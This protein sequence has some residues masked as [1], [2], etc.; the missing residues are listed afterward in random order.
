MKTLKAQRGFFDFGLGLTLLAI[1]G[2]SAVTIDSNMD[3]AT[4]YVEQRATPVSTEVPD[5]IAVVQAGSE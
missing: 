2:G 3:E 1:F 5:E 4:S